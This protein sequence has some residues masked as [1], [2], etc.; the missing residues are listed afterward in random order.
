[1]LEWVKGAGLRPVLHHLD[2]ES[3]ERFLAAYRER[4]AAA[5]PRRRDGKTLYPFTRLFIVA[6]V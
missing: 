1:V 4:L 2:P 5:Y 6:T 3:R